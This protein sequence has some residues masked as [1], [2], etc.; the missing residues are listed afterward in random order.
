MTVH[1][2]ALVGAGRM[3]SLHG[4]NAASNPRFHLAAVADQD[5]ASAE[6]LAGE[7]GAEARPFD[8]V[9]ADPAIDAALIKRI[10]DA[11]PGVAARRAGSQEQAS[12]Q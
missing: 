11:D 7:L 8:A 10:I 12:A 1:R 9:L 4:P 5:S 2:V 6:R 3:G